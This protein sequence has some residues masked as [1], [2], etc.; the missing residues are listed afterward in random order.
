M[1]INYVLHITEHQHEQK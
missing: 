1:Y